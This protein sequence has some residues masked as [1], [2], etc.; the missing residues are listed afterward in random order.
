MT[1]VHDHAATET[2]PESS[3]PTRDDATATT[4]PETP[5]INVEW[6]GEYLLGKWAKARKESRALMANPELHQVDGLSMADHRERV[7][8]QMSILVDNGAI[9]RAFPSALGGQDDHG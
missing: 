2:A 7:F 9:Q 1:Q 6:L 4:N 5:A 3:I 8:N